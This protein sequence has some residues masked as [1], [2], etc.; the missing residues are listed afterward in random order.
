MRIISVFPA[1]VLATASLSLLSCA[2][3]VLRLPTGK[4]TEAPSGEDWIDLF[5]AEN[6]P[7]WKNVT[8]SASTAFTLTENGMKMNPQK[9]TRYIAWTGGSFSDFEL[10]VEFKCG[11]DANSGVFFRTDPADPVQRGM[12]IQVF[13]DHGRHPSVHSSAALYDIATPAFN[14][15]LPP[16][17]WN[18]YDISVDGDQVTVIYN[19]WKVLDLDLGLMT[20][21]IGKF[22]TPLASLP[23]E[24]HIILQNHG[25]EVWFRNLKIRPKQ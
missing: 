16:G 14:M 7:L 21:P 17:E 10:H 23:K 13:G 1:L 8:D 15:A 5:S 9:E 22:D 18:S 11:T 4:A 20:M 3:D 24:G 2:D 19:G 6:A 25:D 12:E